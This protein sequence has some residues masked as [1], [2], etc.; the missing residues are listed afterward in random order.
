MALH[1]S[2]LSPCLFWFL[3]QLSSTLF[4]P[5]SPTGS[6]DLFPTLREAWLLCSALN[7]L[8]GNHLETQHHHH[9]DHCKDGTGQR[10]PESHNNLGWRGPLEVNW[11]IPH[12]EQGQRSSGPCQKT[13]PFGQHREK[14]KTC[15]ETECWNS[16]ISPEAAED[17]SSWNNSLQMGTS[18]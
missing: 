11:S 8:P 18:R 15:E 7:Q 2:M 3:T 5:A 6:G 12:T 10:I 17:K 16:E 13:W 1:S 14:E 9:D 4:S